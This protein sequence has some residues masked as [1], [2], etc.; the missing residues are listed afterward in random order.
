MRSIVRTSRRFMLLAALLL[1]RMAANGT[2]LVDK[3]KPG[4]S[5]KLERLDELLGELHLANGTE[6]AAS[7]YLREAREAYRRW[8]GYG[9]IQL[10]W[11]RAA[12]P[13][14]M[15]WRNFWATRTSRS[16]S[17]STTSTV[18]DMAFRD[19]TRSIRRRRGRPHHFRH[20]RSTGTASLHHLFRR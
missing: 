2:Y 14:P 18:A 10:W 9:W 7:Y 4:Y 15:W 1:A 17:S 13:R 6:M 12:S 19:P 3:Q 5:S 20:R 11:Q 8:G 16:A